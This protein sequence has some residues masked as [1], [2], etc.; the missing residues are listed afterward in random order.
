MREDRRAL[1]DGRHADAGD[2]GTVPAVLTRYQS[3]LPTQGQALDL[4]CGRGAAALWLAARGFSVTAWDYSTVAI[5]KLRAEALARH[6]V[7]DAQIRNVLEAPPAAASV[8][9]LLVSHFLDR[10]L[11]PAIGA[12][13][14]PGGLLCYQTFGP[15]VTGATGPA[16]PDYRLASNELLHLFPSLVVRAYLEPG[17][18]SDPDDPLRGLALLVAE[19]TR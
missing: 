18:H 4:A 11:C 17:E 8:D 7:I 15:W 6:Q 12:A 3:L 1:W 9:L 19:K 10:S 2:L 16:N 5:E 14:K 13:L